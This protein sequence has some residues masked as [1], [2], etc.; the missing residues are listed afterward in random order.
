MASPKATARIVLDKL[1]QED[2]KRI[3]NSV[4]A[5]TID[6][7]TDADCDRALTLA[8]RADL[9]RGSIVAAADT[10][11]DDRVDDPAPKPLAD[12]AQG[13]T[14]VPQAID[15]IGEAYWTRRKAATN[16]KA[17]ESHDK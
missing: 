10:D 16:A 4:G 8:G 7:L 2:A 12:A 1:P 15:S 13:T 17:E 6:D 5:K 3:L 9:V 14:S 11:R